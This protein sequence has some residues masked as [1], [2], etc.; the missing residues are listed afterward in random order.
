MDVVEE[1]DDDTIVFLMQKTLDALLWAQCIQLHH[2][3]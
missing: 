3:K 1:N 2:Y